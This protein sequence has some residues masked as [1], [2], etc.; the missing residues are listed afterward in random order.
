MPEFSSW[1]RVVGNIPQSDRDEILREGKD[2]FGDQYFEGLRGAEREKT[3]EEMQIISLA[4][5]MTNKM[6]L[7][8][9]LERFD[10]PPENIHI[11]VE[12]KWPKEESAGFFNLTAQSI[13]VCEKSSYIAFAKIVFH[14]MTHFKSYTAVQITQEEQPRFQAYRLGLTVQTRDG[15]KEYFRNINEAITEELTKRFIN[16]SLENSLFVEEVNKTRDVKERYPHTRT[17]SGEIL[18]NEDVFYAEIRHKI[19]E[20]GMEALSENVKNSNLEISTENF[21]YRQERQILHILIDAL[22]TKNPDMF[23]DREEVFEIFA[24]GMITGNIL[25]V[26]RLIDT[27]FGKGTFRRIGDLD[28]DIQKQEE[29]VRSLL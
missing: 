28:K 15:Q 8:Y 16:E 26:G 13:F 17:S 22:Y 7:K 14:E 3:P 6:R 20:D 2:R 5:E 10:I 21:T 4:N 29:F 23:Q 27:T 11:I 1:E 25:P 24:K 12:E 9:D 18:F 19:Q